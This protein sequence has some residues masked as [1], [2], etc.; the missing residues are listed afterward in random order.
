METV[1]KMLESALRA[2]GFLSLAL[3]FLGGLLSSLTPCVYPMIP[4]T[5][6]IIGGQKQLSRWHS[7]FLSLFYV[8]GIA[9]TYTALGVIAVATGSLFGSISSNVIVLFIVANIC[10]LFGLSMLDV[11][12]LNLPFLSGIN[13]KKPKGGSFLRVFV[14]GLIFGLVASPC[15]APVLG[16]IL[17]F[18]ATSKSYVFGAGCMFLYALGMG[19]LLILIGTFSGAVQ[20]LPR[21]GAWMNIV[22]K[23][24][25][26]IMILMGEYFLVQMGKGMF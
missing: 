11:F 16:V 24:F 2:Q 18:V 21:A 4:I 17:A 22:K 1:L 12:T 3:V 8:L 19:A 20:R 26:G 6:S 7:F 10:I 25:G 15:T 5:V 23:V 9:A 13:S 14:L